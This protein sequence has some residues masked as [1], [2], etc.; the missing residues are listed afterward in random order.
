MIYVL[1]YA[2][3]GI[4]MKLTDH[5][6]EEGRYENGILT[7]LLCGALVGHLISSHAPSTFILGGIIVG[8]LAAGKVDYIGHYM[9]LAAAFFV[10][11]YSF[12]PPVELFPL[13]FV[14]AGSFLDEFLHPSQIKSKVARILEHRPVLKLVILFYFLNGTITFTILM[15]F[16]AFEIAYELG[17]SLYEKTQ[18]DHLGL[19]RR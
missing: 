17:G 6:G 15:A 13:V 9:G 2:L 18:R 7:G 3:V 8:T 12:T 5:F 11:I 19:R 10:I 14:S 16:L 4:L 1:A